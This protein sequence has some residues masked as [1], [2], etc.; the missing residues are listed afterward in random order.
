MKGIFL[1]KVSVTGRLPDLQDKT[2]QP[3]SQVVLRQRHTASGIDL[4]RRIDAIIKKRTHAEKGMQ[5]W[6]VP[7]GG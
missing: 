2:G 1:E 7:R 4:G 5:S 6:G 3:R